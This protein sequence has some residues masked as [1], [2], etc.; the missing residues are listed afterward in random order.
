LA[1]DFTNIHIPGCHFI[2]NT[3]NQTTERKLFGCRI[4][5]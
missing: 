2:P 5:N 3:T 4:T 1:L